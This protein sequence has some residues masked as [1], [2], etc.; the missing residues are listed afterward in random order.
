[1]SDLG[2]KETL[3]Q[4]TSWIRGGQIYGLTSSGGQ[5]YFLLY[6]MLIQEPAFSQEGN[7]CLYLWS[8]FFLGQDNNSKDNIR[9]SREPEGT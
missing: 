3:G 9:Y 2:Q 8:F 1:M 7:A 6:L 4:V 5:Q